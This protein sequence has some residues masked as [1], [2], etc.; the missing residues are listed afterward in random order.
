MNL[1]LLKSCLLLAGLAGSLPVAFAQHTFP[2]DEY[3]KA[4]ITAEGGISIGFQN[5][6]VTT[7]EV[8]GKLNELLNLPDHFSFV[9][10]KERTDARGVTHSRLTQYYRDI[11][12][13]GGTVLLHSKNDQVI[14]MSGKIM[15]TPGSPLDIQPVVGADAARET[16]L[17]ASDVV[18]PINSYNPELVIYQGDKNPGLAYK[19]R[20]DG[21]NRKGKLTMYQVYISAITGKV[22]S[23][24]SLIAHGD[25][26]A[27]AA[28][29]Y[30]GVRPIITD[31]FSGGYR[32]KDNMRR[33][34]TY[35]AT[36]L[37]FDTNGAPAYTNPIEVTNPT[38]TW[39]PRL[40]LASVQLQSVTDTARYSMGFLDLTRGITSGWVMHNQIEKLITPPAT[41]QSIKDGQVLGDL[42]TTGKASSVPIKDALNISLDAASYRGAFSRDSVR[43]S[44]GSGGPDFMTLK[45]DT[46]KVRYTIDT[47]TPGNHQWSNPRGDKGSYTIDLKGEPAIDVHWGIEKTYDF[48]KSIFSYYSYNNDSTAIIRNYYDGI[49]QISGD[50]NNAMAL[51]SPYFAMVYGTGDGVSLNP[52]V[53]LDV[54]GHEFT[55]LITASNANLN[56]SGESGAL[57][58]SFS[59]MM[60]QAIV[61]FAKGMD[62][63]T[64]RAGERVLVTSPY[65]RSLADPKGPATFNGQPQPHT[66]QGQYWADTTDHGERNDY[67]GVHT[68]SG[69]GNKWFYLIAHG[70]SG[71]NDNQYT[72]N[73]TG[74]GLAKAQ[75]IAFS[76]FTDYLTATSKYI[77]AYN[78]SLQATATIY[79]QSSVEYNTV[80][81]AWKAVG[82]PK[83]GTTGIDHTTADARSIELYPNPSTGIINIKS[84]RKAAVDAG[85]YNIAGARILDITITPGT[86]TYDVTQLAKGIYFVEYHIG[87]EKYSHKLV[88]Q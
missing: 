53:I 45:Q 7:A 47:L 49:A 71:V 84:A 46:N 4:N 66:Y 21:Y 54:V 69:V 28:T 55:H 17:K 83:S 62:S 67:G 8:R 18:K 23:R 9:K 24:Q 39:G 68:N 56:Y 82:I 74:L 73:I 79:G 3:P 61:G 75:E 58:E 29:Y 78:G 20:I 12:V 6:V 14:S 70:G 41:Y 44:F 33:I 10:E 19:T 65:M 30:S 31:N 40:K 76:S 57:N 37:V 38:T 36:G 15:T 64:W 50:Q 2:G 52:V 60:G 5:Q 35:Y 80:K 87:G 32:L 86:R 81:E 51:P 25:V 77:D 42:M 48:Y 85:I 26:P 59:D 11:K 27:T 43:L 1:K 22:L 72:Y 34:E 16:A 88:L 63:V 13:E